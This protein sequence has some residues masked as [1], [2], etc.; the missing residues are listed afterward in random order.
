MIGKLDRVPLRDVWPKEAADFTPWLR[1]NI[2]V[3]NEVLDISLT[4][5]ESE[6]RA[7]S[8]NVDIVAEDQSGQTVI[9]ENQLERSDHDHLGKLIT[10]LAVLDAKAAVWIVADPR[11]EHVSAVSWLNESS[12]ASFYLVKAEAVRIGDSLPAPFLTLIVG[13][14]EDR[15]EVVGTKREL[16]ERH[17]I[18]Q[19]FW[20]R[21]LD[22]AKEKFY[23]TL[24]S[25]QGLKI[26]S[27]QVLA[28]PVW[29]SITSLECMIQTWNYTLIGETRRRIRLSLISF[30]NSRRLLS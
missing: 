27:V 5:A 12:E 22:L 10:Y 14:S 9:I 24:I 13:P 1:D 11:P 19:R 23:F 21:L 30:M 15:N 25:L 2:D 8:L 4:G 26:G 29:L 6:Q 7:G 20:S 16:A 17:L 3:L 18:R 28:K